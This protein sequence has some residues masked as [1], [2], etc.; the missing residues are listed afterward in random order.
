M[1]VLISLKTAEDLQGDALLYYDTE[2]E[3]M[4][5]ILLSIP[6][7]IYNSVDACTSANMNLILLSIPNDIYNSI[8]A[9]TSAKDM[10]KRVERLMRGTIQNK[11]DRETRFTNEFDQF[12]A[13]PGEALVSVYNPHTGSSSRNTSS[14]YVTHPTFVVDYEDEY[15]QDDVHTNSEDPLASAMLLLARAITQKFSNPTN[16]RLRTSSNTRNQAI[17]QGDRV[18]IQSRNSGNTSTV[19]CYNCSG[20]GHYARNCP[21]PRN[22]FLF[23]DASRMEEIEELSAN[24]CLMSKIQPADNTF[25]AG[26]SSDSAFIDF[27]PQKELSA[28]Q[29]Y[30]PSS[31]IPSDKTSNATPSIPTSMPNNSLHAEIEQIKKKSIE[32]QEGLQ[33][34]IKILEKD[35]Q[36]CEKQSVNFELKLQHEKEKHKWDLILKNK[37]TNP[38]DYSWI[39]K[40]E[41]LEDENVSLDFKVQSLIKECGNVKLEYQ[42]LFNSIKKT[43]S[44]TQ[45]EMDKIIAHVSEKTYGYGAIRAENH[46]LLFTISELK[47]RLKNVEKGKSINTKFDKTNGSQTL[48]CVTP[49]NK[50]VILK[51]TDVLKSEENHVVSKLVTLQTSPAK[52]R[53]ANSKENVIAPGMYKVVTT[54]ESQTNEA[55]HGLSSTGMN[56][57]SSFRRPINRDSHVQD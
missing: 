47:T 7:D 30:F 4:N 53:E 20:K 26:T 46:N 3:L 15:Q 34:R 2:K 9:C 16:N 49:L 21:K 36:R 29:K 44:Q 57:V 11:V 10:W 41:K 43:W 13:E 5:L 12:V 38:L 54:H 42:N 33:A 51:K 50:Q 37:K 27:V 25:D 1:K 28:E 6:N 48:L 22:D 55:K 39:S 8:D 18:N 35:V 56:D 17:I 32:I 19:Q 40:M 24:I 52:Q 14:Y 31:F 23:A 45:K